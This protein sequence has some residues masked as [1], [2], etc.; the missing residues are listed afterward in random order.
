MIIKNLLRR[1]GRTL[2]TMLGISIGVAA[3]IGLGSMA[4]GLN[5]G[6]TSMVSGSK[7]DLVLSQPDSYDISMS[8]VD[9]NVQ[10]ELEGMPEISSFSAMVQG[11]VA[12]DESPYFFIFGYPEDSFIMPRFIINQGVGFDS[13]ESK[14]LHGKPI[15]IGKSASE[16]LHKNVGDTLRFTGKTFRIIGIYQTGDAF[17]DSG[18][19]LKLRDAQELLGKTHQVSLFYIQLKDPSLGDRLK[20]RVERLWPD[21]LLAGSKEFTNKQGMVDNLRVTMWVISGLAILIGGVG[22]MNSQLMAVYERTREIGVLRAIGWPSSSVL[23]MILGETIVVCFL[24]GIVGVFLGWIFLSSFSTITA[25]WGVSKTYLEPGLL[26]QAFGVVLVLGIVGGLYPAWRAS[27]LQ[28]IEALRYEGGFGGKKARHFPFG[29]MA[30]QSLW[31]RT[32]RTI[33]T[34]GGIALTIGAI[35][36]MEGLV[37]G[38]TDSIT[39][40]FSSDSEIMIRQ[41]NIADTSYSAID[42]KIGDKLEA[43]ADVENVS[44]LI[45]TAVA[46]PEAGGFFILQ[47][48]RPSD[49]AI[50]RFNIVE[51]QAINNNRQVMIGRM[52]ADSLKKSVGE[53]IDLGGSRFK[54]VGIYE[55]NVSWEELGGVISLRDAQTLTGK[56]RKVTMYSLNLADHV[57]A[58]KLVGRINSSIPDVHASLAGDF[59]DQMADM[60]NTYAMMDG[61]NFMAILIGGLGVMN[62]MLMAVLERTREIGVMRALGWRRRD[63]LGLILRE[64]LLLG[65]LGG[66]L[67]VL[68]AVGLSVILSLSSGAAEM[69]KPV[70][71]AGLILQSIIAATALGLVGGLYPAFR[72]TRQ[73]P[74]EAL[75][76][77]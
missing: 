55:S 15:L 27:R 44:G 36:S 62:T 53:S 12:T 54:I 22:M 11:I 64:S 25:S 63:I 20:T 31:S 76:Y 30:V 61:L 34:L 40:M 77:E 24:G 45:F 65:A 75:R 28:P 2:L 57:D 66:V 41:S 38:M 48:Y 50:S 10:N 73:E 32:T 4:E 56:P 58:G 1:K 46:M 7:A 16:T 71:S 39:S 13:P 59:V 42:E 9:E 49:Y 14:R 19:V 21:L 43:M 8:T 17:E 29:G 72:A 47:G 69:Y 33:L 68:M 70:F 74:I 5:S 35:L 37:S 6:Y 3:I 18:A 26:L 23:W 67:G 52:V 51:G 60:Q